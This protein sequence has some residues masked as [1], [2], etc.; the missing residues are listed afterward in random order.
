MIKTNDGSYSENTVKMVFSSSASEG[1]F[2]FGIQN[3]SWCH[4][5]KDPGPISFSFLSRFAFC[6]DKLR[7][8]AGA[9]AGPKWFRRFG[10]M[11]NDK[12]EQSPRALSEAVNALC[13]SYYDEDSQANHLGQS[14]LP[15]REVTI[16]ILEA[17]KD[18]LFPDH[19]MNRQVRYGQTGYIVG[20][21]LETVHSELRQQIYLARSYDF[22]GA[23][24]CPF[25]LE[26][27]DNDALRF[28]QTLPA[29]REALAL[30]VQAALDGDPAA[31]SKDE[32]IFCY[33]GFEA[34][35]TYRI[36]HELN[37]LEIPLL[38]RMMSEYA[39][40]R[41]GTDIHPGARIGRSFFVDHATGVVVG[42]TTLIGD[43]VKLYQGVTLGA[44]SFPQDEHGRLLR[45]TKRHPTIEDD[46]VIYAGATVLGGETTIGRGAVIGGSCWITSSIPAGTKVVLQDPQMR[47]KGPKAGTDE[48]VP[49]VADWNI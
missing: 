28:I 14:D 15:S 38:P 40:G 41:T 16:G 33:P 13:A 5:A 25:T 44:L 30:D 2:A 32:I 48:A 21:V 45:N 24:A 23:A 9:G 19:R 3:F 8:L 29:L 36:A 10:A 35:C 18:V 26:H 7:A 49:Y 27:A 11:A 12:K 1:F 22:G 42:E 39:H 31:H 4:F 6:R 20:G 43:R 37:R 47:M 17:V 34:V 46:V